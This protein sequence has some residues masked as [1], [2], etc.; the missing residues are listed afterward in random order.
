MRSVNRLSNG[1]QLGDGRH[2]RNG[3]D[4]V[5]QM[6][7]C[8]LA[9]VTTPTL[10]PCLASHLNKLIAVISLLIVQLVF[11]QCNQLLISL[12]MN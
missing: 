5:L 8:L 9:A 12:V 3:A 7:N 1:R 11:V 2:W 4:A 6:Q 10:C